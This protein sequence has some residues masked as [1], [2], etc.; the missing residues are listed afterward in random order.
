M[1]NVF[2][3]NF[4]ENIDTEHKAYLLGWIAGCGIIVENQI[5]IE[6]NEKD[7]DIIEILRDMVSHEIP[8]SKYGNLLLNTDIQVA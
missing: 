2:N 5:G 6:S 8:I 7:I 3:D 1:T 4:L